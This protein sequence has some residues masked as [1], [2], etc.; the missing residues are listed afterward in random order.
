[1]VWMGGVMSLFIRIMERLTGRPVEGQKMSVL[2]DDK[3]SPDEIIALARRT[4]RALHEEI[5]FAP[6]G[7]KLNII[8]TSNLPDKRENKLIGGSMIITTSDLERGAQKKPL[9]TQGTADRAG[10]PA[11]KKR[12]RIIT[13]AD[14]DDNGRP[15]GKNDDEH[16]S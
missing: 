7:K 6:P 5:K 16:T 3:D 14:L 15:K 1:M 9:T 13:T 4:M 8:T 2:C 12:N 10:V 11:P